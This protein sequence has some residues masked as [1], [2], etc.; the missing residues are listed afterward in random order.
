M[1][2]DEGERGVVFGVERRGKFGIGNR[3]VW[4]GF[5][6]S[7]INLCLLNARRILGN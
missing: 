1:G 4:A 6:E 2:G 7:F 5:N 3:C